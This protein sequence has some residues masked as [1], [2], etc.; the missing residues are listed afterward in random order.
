[1]T[2]LFKCNSC[3][4]DKPDDEFNH[5]KKDL[6]RKGKFIH[7]KGDRM[8]NCSECMYKARQK[9]YESMMKNRKI[10]D[11]PPPDLSWLSMAGIMPIPK[12][13]LK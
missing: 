8:P 12:K 4:Q 5:F 9:G 11:T 1:M 10:R 6:V 7:G 2:E 13:E 3:G